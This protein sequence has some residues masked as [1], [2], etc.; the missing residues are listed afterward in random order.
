MITNPLKNGVLTANPTGFG[1][2]ARKTARES[3][4]GSE[5][6]DPL[7]SSTGH[8]APRVA[9]DDEDAK[10]RNHRKRLVEG[11]GKEASLTGGA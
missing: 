10:Y 5:H 2:M 7:S 6:W 1:T 8:A 9:S 11:G 3:A 4:P